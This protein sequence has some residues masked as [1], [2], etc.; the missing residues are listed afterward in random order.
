MSLIDDVTSK[1]LRLA[2]IICVPLL[3]VAAC[4]S[5]DL[6]CADSNSKTCR[7]TGVQRSDDVTGSIQSPHTTSRQGIA[8][9][10]PPIVRPVRVQYAPHVRQSNTG[11]THLRV[12]SRN[13]PH[14]TRRRVADC[15]E[16]TG[17][18]APLARYPVT[19]ARTPIPSRENRQ[20]TRLIE[21]F[22][23]PGETLYSI[24]RRYGVSV[25]ALASYNVIRNAALI[26][27]GTLIFVPPT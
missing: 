7:V 21:H 20:K 11:R 22:V 10:R 24:A 17:S 27:T 19:T 12:A 8:M 3:F 18:I 14:A 23:A 2:I 15:S 5:T 16:V 13:R 9:V 26:K 4:S 1:R 6:T 25:S